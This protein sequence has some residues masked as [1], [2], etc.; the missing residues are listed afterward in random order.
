MK[1]FACAALP[2][3]LLAACGSS[4]NI[5]FADDEHP[6][7]PVGEEQ[8]PTVADLLDPPPQAAPD[9]LDDIVDRSEERDEDE[10]DLPP[11]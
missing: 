1:T 11:N 4:G 2:L 5:A 9:R 6:P 7:A 10:F 8:A 3:L